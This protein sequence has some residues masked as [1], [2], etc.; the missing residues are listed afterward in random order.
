MFSPQSVY[1]QI[2]CVHYDV[3]HILESIVHIFQN[4]RKW[5]TKRLKSNFYFSF[6]W[7]YLLMH[8][9]NRLHVRFGKFFLIKRVVP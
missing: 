5:V 3:K 4:S 9:T 1:L 6:T 2:K 7:F 8:V